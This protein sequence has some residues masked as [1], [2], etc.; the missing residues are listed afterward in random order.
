M[1]KNGDFNTRTEEG[2]DEQS[3]LAF[4]ETCTETGQCE[5]SWF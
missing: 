4:K 1:N 2:W 3:S 5:Q